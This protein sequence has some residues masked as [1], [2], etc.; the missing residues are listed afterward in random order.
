MAL[1]DKASR[2]RKVKCEAMME[3]PSRLRAS[4]ATKRYVLNWDRE[5]RCSVLN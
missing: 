4:P 1:L 3:S 5:T 2:Q